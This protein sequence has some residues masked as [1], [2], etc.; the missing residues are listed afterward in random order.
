MS[1]NVAA[2]YISYM[3]PISLILYKR[4]RQDPIKEKIHWGPWTMG[5]I[6]GPI[7]NM[8]GLIYSSITL[9]FSFFPATQTVTLASMNWSFLLFSGAIIFS[10]SFYF[11][12]GKD[13]YKWPIVDPNR[14][15]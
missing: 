5:P 1:V 3:I 14:H 8:I 11:I 10:V 6:F 12:F 4:I 15:Q 13:N 7:V 2:F 9:F